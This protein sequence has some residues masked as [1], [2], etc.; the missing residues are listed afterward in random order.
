MQRSLIRHPSTPCDAISRI[1]ADA[2]RSADGGLSLR[3]TAHGSIDGLLLP[4]KAKAERTDL[5]WQH[6]CF[7]A[8]IKPQPGTAYT[9]LNASPSSG[10]ALYSF[11]S[12]REEMT[13]APDAIQISPIDVK[14]A[15]GSLILATSIRGLEHTFDWR[16]ALSAIIEEKSGRKSFWALKHPPEKPD[17]HHDDCFDLQLPAPSRA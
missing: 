16:I 10:W 5:L 15:P 2:E 6:T 1:E 14:I 8:F 12:F 3:Y 4:V 7:E 9:E 17:F 13:E 11:S